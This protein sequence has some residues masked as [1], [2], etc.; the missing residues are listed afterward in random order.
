MFS[1]IPGTTPAPRALFIKRWGTIF[2]TPERGFAQDP[3]EVEFYSG[4]RET[5]FRASRS[6]WTIYLLGNEPA[7]GRGEL[8]QVDWERVEGRIIESLEG[9]GIAI[10]RQ[11]VCTDNPEAESKNQLDSVYLLPNTGAFYHAAHVDG[12]DLAKSWIIGDSTVEVVAGWRAGCRQAGVKTGLGLEDG[13]FHVD[14]ALHRADLATVLGEL[15][16][17]QATLRT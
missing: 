2:R 15:L 13:E 11:Y 9:A 5:L 6:G 17:Q 16:E 14:P 8:T 1:P 3:D 10:G 4:S 12:I 7:V